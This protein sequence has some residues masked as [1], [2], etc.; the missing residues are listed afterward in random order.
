MMDKHYNTMQKMIGE[1][2]IKFMLVTKICR[3]FT[4]IYM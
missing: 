1:E 3:H 4:Y 2:N